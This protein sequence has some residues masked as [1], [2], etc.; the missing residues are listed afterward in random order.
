RAI[1]TGFAMAILAALTFLV[2]DHAPAASFYPNQDAYSA[3]LGFVPQIVLAS[4]LGYVT[5]QFLNS[6]VLVRMKARSAEPRLW[7]RLASSTGVGEAADT[8]IFCAIASSAIG[9][10][11]MGG[12]WNYFVVGFVYKCGV[13]LLVMPL[14]VVVIRLLKN[15]EPSYWE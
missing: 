6:Y 1:F 4:V 13:E 11:T 8:L 7:A 3:V 9:I 15:R 2:V 14:T 12:F 5:G 10:T